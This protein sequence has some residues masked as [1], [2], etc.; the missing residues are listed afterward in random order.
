MLKIF[1]S[2]LILVAIALPL[3]AELYYEGGY[4]PNQTLQQQLAEDNPRYPRPII[5]VSVSY[6]H[7]TLPTILLV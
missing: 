7:L 6:T 3:H 4:N 2:F 5:F 1:W